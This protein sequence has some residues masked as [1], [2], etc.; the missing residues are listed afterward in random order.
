MARFPT[1]PILIDQLLQ[2]STKDL[3]VL[4]YL[5]GHSYNA[6]IINW[7]R[8]KEITASISVKVDTMESSPFL[9]LDYR[10][11]NNPL[12]Y[13]IQLVSIPSNLG[14]G[15]VWYFICPNTAKRCRKLYLA[16]GFFVSRFAF[17]HAMY[18]KQTHSHRSRNHN[19]MLNKFC[20]IDKSI[21]QLDKPYFKK[22]YAGKET[23]QYI[24]I[25]KEIREFNTYEVKDFFD[26]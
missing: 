24:R 3:R 23:K 5:Y 20:S 6:G 11:K 18:E 26:F 10:Y 4:K 21:K 7:K 25:L 17:T 13:R 16:N 19:I 2:L 15:I 9:E 1:S 8:E 12:N 14:K 22:C